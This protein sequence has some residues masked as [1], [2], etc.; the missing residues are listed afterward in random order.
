MLTYCLKCRKKTESKNLRVAK[1]KKKKKKKKKVKLI[2]LSKCGVCDSKKSRFVKK[3][4]A[5]GF[6]S[7]L[8]IRTPLSKILLLGDNF[9]EI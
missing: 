5:T 2:L 4:E 7:N 6:L 8:R 1:K 9:L 3:Q